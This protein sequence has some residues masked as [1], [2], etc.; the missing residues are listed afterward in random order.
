MARR[1]LGPATLDVVKAVEAALVPEDAYLL[2]ACS[3]GADSLALAVATQQVLRR[4]NLPGSAV[5]V[6]H[7]LQPGSLDAAQAARSQLVG[8]GYR[9]AQVVTVQVDDDS[10]L[11]PEAAARAARYQALATAARARSATVLLGHTLDDQAETVLLGLARGSGTRSL[12]GMSVRTGAYLRPML[13]LR[14]ATT[15]QACVECGL[16]P[17]RDP[18]NTDDRYA[19]VRVRSRL[20]PMLEAELGPGIAESLSRTARLAKDDAD[21]LDALAVE[22]HPLTDT[23]ECAALLT[24]P[25]ALRRRAI[26]TW[27]VAVGALE[28]SSRHVLAVEELVVRWHGQQAIDLPGIRVARVDGRLVRPG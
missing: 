7:G 22:A 5:V 16:E 23:L 13:G 15:E 18:H 12:A 26:R 27:L 9:E 14:R 8:M 19:R 24:S 21:L 17:W 20:L 4:R 3:G 28:V 2:V 1:A 10:H 25:P 6:D 11:G